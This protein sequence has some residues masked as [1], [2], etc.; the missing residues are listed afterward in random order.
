M[1]DINAIVRDTPTYYY[2]A[3]RPVPVSLLPE[4]YNAPLSFSP[5]IVFTVRIVWVHSHKRFIHI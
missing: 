5:T 4:F 2:D 3:G 1:L